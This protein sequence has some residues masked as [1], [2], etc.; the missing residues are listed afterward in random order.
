M[1]LVLLLIA[2]FLGDF[3]F[4][5]KKLVELKS[6][7]FRFQ[8]LHS[9]IYAL[10]FLGAIVLFLDFFQ[11]LS[12]AIIIF[13]LHLLIDWLRIKSDKENNTVKH[14]FVSFVLDQVAHFAILILVTFGTHVLN[15]PLEPTE[16]FSR[17]FGIHGNDIQI[18]SI[19]LSYIVVLSPASVFIKNFLSLFFN[20]EDENLVESSEGNVGSLIGKLERV[21]ILTLGLMSLYS[22]IA[23]VLTAKSIARFRQLEDRDFAEKYLVGTLLS[24]IIDIACIGMVAILTN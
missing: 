7:N 8:I 21:L 22:S 5:P 4:Q 2:H 12:I 6:Q 15:R 10:L 20:K 17:L 1:A 9:L 14:Y 19:I 18:S 13:C 16:F 11:A 23:L 24:M 3:T